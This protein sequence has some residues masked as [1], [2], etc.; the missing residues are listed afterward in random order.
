MVKSAGIDQAGLSSCPDN[1]IPHP[2]S[3][4]L[5]KPAQ[6]NGSSA[7]KMVRVIPERK[8]KRPSESQPSLGH[9]RRDQEICDA[10]AEAMMEMVAALR[11]RTF[12][13][14]PTDDRFTITNC[15]KA[16]DEIESIDQR[17]YFAALDLFENPNL[18]ETFISLKDEKLRLT[19]LQE[20]CSNAV[21]C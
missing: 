1:E 21:S 10:M 12:A 7:E 9:S 6:I 18:R 3:F 5:S 14:V 11:C 19:W 17:L 13:T 4:P 20:K 16:L 2:E 8:K 15:I